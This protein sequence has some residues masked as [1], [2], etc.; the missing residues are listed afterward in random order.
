MPLEF[1]G[2][3]FQTIGHLLQTAWAMDGIQN[4]IMRGLGLESVLL[5]AGIML[6]YAV[7]FFALAVWRFRF[8]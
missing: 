4:I 8:E 1:T 6:A 5:P 3:T 2:K 7:A